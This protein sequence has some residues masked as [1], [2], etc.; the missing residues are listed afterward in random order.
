MDDFYITWIYNSNNLNLGDSDFCPEGKCPLPATNE[1]LTSRLYDGDVRATCLR[2]GDDAGSPQGI[3]LILIILGVG[4]FIGLA[5]FT[6]KYLMA[7][8]KL[9][10]ELESRRSFITQNEEESLDD[11]RQRQVTSI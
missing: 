11:D 5:Y 9:H 8:R 6:A 10:S 3:I 1:Y 2:T 4:G 7:R